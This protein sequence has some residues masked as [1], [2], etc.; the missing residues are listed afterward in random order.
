MTAFEQG[1]MGSWEDGAA[2]LE[3]VFAAGEEIEFIIL[4]DAW[5]AY[6][7]APFPA[8]EAGI[9]R[10]QERAAA[11]GADRALD[12]YVA[13]E[14]EPLIREVN[15]GIRGAGS[16]VPARLYNRLGNLLVQAGR[17]GEAKTAYERAA[18]MGSAAGMVN[19]G[20]VAFL[21]NDFPA[22]RYWFTEAL[23]KESDNRTAR[24]GMERLGSRGL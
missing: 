24:R 16:E 14:I 11:A 17:Q 4:E 7:P 6:P 15:A 9:P 3:K 23:K 13:A 19:R 10:P 21:E 18:S 20:N 2:K 22:A 5:T 1:F 8:M 12:R